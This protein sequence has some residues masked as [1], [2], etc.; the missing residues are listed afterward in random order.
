M[1]FVSLGMVISALLLFV[2]LIVA[3]MLLPASKATRKVEEPTGS[4]APVPATSRS[5]L[6]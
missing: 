6:S 2:V 5:K 4:V 3:W 1:E